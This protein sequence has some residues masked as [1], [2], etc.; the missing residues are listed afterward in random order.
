MSLWNEGKMAVV[1]GLGRKD[2]GRS[3]FEVKDAAAKGV[4]VEL[5]RETSNGWLA[6]SIFGYNN[7]FCTPGQDPCPPLP[8]WQAPPNVDGISLGNAAAGPNALEASRSIAKE[9]SFNHMTGLKSVDDIVDADFSFQYN[10]P[11]AM[12][13]EEMEEIKT[14]GFRSIHHSERQR[15]QERGQVRAQEHARELKAKARRKQALRAATDAEMW[16]QHQTNLGLEELLRKEQT[17]FQ[18]SLF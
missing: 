17:I 5:E 10:N 15:R 7:L 3:H 14:T 13:M 6:K 1:P 4:S 2:H 9:G 18:V 11:F 16:A 8:E 12:M